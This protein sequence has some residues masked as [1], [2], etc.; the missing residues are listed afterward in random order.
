MDVYM[1]KVFVYVTPMHHD[2]IFLFIQIHLNKIPC[3]LPYIV[4]Y[5]SFEYKGHLCF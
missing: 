3:L 4:D 5:D 1:K 2:F